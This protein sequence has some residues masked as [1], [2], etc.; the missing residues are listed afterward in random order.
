M[1]VALY[2]DPATRRDVNC[3]MRH[4]IQQLTVLV[5]RSDRKSDMIQKFAPGH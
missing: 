1:P 2:A 4:I 5:N 3:K